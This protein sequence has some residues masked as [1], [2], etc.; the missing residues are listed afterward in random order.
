MN[1]DTMNKYSPVYNATTGEQITGYGVIATTKDLDGTKILSMW[2][3]TGQDTYYT[4][5][6]FAV[7]WLGE[8][9]ERDSCCTTAVV[10]EIDYTKH[11]TDDC[12]IK[13][14]EQLGTITEYNNGLITNEFNYPATIADQCIPQDWTNSSDGSGFSLYHLEKRSNTL[15]ASFATTESTQIGFPQLPCDW[16]FGINTATVVVKLVGTGDNSG[17]GSIELIQ[18]VQRVLTP[19]EYI[20]TEWG[21]LYVKN[22]LTIPGDLT[23][24]PYIVVEFL[25]KQPPIHDP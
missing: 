21:W 6:A 12:F 1:V 8:K 17:A 18:P 4:C 20:V 25:F 24:P 9:L 2:G 3:L 19:D 14:V 13:I 7:N 23:G 16:A 5:W 15:D 11:P 22:G 10:I